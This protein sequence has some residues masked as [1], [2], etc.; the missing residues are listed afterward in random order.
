LVP[1]APQL[2]R[3]VL[4]LI[5]APLQVVRLLGHWLAHFPVAQTSAVAHLVV[6][7]PQLL[8][9]DC[10]LTQVPLQLVSVL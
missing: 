2:S 1:Q 6:Q 4:V 8:R 10:R 9:S 7:A 5:Q 3:S